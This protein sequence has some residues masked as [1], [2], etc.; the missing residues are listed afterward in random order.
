MGRNCL[1]GTQGAREPPKG[2]STGAADEVKRL[3]VPYRQR[4]DPKY[5]AKRRVTQAERVQADKRSEIKG[6]ESQQ[7]RAKK[8]SLRLWTGGREHE[9][10]GR[11]GVGAG[12]RA[13]VR[14]GEGAEWRRGRDC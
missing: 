13:G 6:E 7:E 2:V 10:G 9:G 14:P 1:G 3:S 11:G 8:A 4:G 12:Q 5:T